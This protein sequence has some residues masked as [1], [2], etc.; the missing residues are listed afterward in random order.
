MVTQEMVKKCNGCAACYSVCPA[1][2]ITMKPDSEGFLY[3]N[4]NNEA[5]IKCGKCKA[6]CP[7]NATPLINSSNVDAYAA[8]NKNKDIRLKSSSGGVFYALA[9]K[10][11]ADGGIVFGPAFDSQNNLRHIAIETSE[12][13]PLLMGSKYLQSNI[14]DCYKSAESYLEQGKTVM[15][16]GTPC[17]IGGLKAFLK[18]DYANLICQDLA[19]HGVPS[20]LVWKKYT[21]YHEKKAHTNIKNIFFRNKTY[22]WK[23]YS[24]TLKYSDNKEYIGSHSLDLYLRMFINNFSLRP[25]CYDCMYKSVERKSDITLADYWGVHN[26]EDGM[27]DNLGTSL[28]I[29]HTEKGQK[30]LN[31]VCKQFIIKKT[32]VKKAVEYNSAIIKSVPMP[33]QREQFFNMLLSDGFSENMENLQYLGF[34]RKAKIRYNLQKQKIKE[35]A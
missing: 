33:P 17:Q 20:P 14:G 21:E 25:S 35:Q 15:F 11:L 34:L 10:I 9:N 1:N 29:I 3:P 24:L 30:L 12:Q 2:C 18:K 23:S 5:C 19:C 31:S 4:V 32:D 6:V 26:V 8:I 22:G 27:D 7:V 16:T 28:V 13:I